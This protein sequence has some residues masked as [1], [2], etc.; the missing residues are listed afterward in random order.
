MEITYL[1]LNNLIGQHATAMV[2]GQYVCLVD[3]AI[4]FACRCDSGHGGDRGPQRPSPCRQDRE[5]EEQKRSKQC[6]AGVS[7]ST[8]A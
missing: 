2:Q 1:Q 6:V 4:F 5:R 8:V 7:L 3:P